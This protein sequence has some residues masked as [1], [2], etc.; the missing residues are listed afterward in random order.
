MKMNNNCLRFGP[1]S[2]SRAAWART[3]S[4]TCGGRKIEL[5]VAMHE[6]FS[7]RNPAQS[8]KATI[9]HNGVALWHGPVPAD[10]PPLRAAVAGCGLLVAGEDGLPLPK[11]MGWDAPEW[12]VAKLS[13]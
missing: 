12:L 13:G 10:G 11:D 5:L 8:R 2:G 6:I 1:K 7:G 9:S 3:L 4:V